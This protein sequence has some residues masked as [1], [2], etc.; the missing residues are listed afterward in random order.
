[1]ETG[2]SDEEEGQVTKRDPSP[3]VDA[4]ATL[5][6]L[7]KCRVTRDKIVRYFLAPWFQEYIQRKLLSHLTPRLLMSLDGWVRYCIGADNQKNI[8]RA[9]QVISQSNVI[10]FSPSPYSLQVSLKG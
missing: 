10:D 3:N 9:C 6:E 7:N 8:Y 1:M 4:P 5:E 2:T